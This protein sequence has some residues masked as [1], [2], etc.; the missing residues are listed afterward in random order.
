M[1]KWDIYRYYWPLMEQD[2]EFHVKTCLICQLDEVEK[3][4]GA[5]LLQPL[6]MPNGPWESLSMDFITRFPKVDGFTS[7][8]IIVGRFSKYAS[9]VLMPKECAT[10]LTAK[11]FMKN[12]VKLWGIPSD[13]VSNRDTQL[14]RR[15]W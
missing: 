7:I 5:G 12:I 4:K 10:E 2:V 15:F 11:F 13:I 8:M 14:T 1:Q 9:F 6:P 3:R